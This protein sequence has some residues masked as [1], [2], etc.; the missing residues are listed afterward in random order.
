MLFA[1]QDTVHLSAASHVEITALIA[2]DAPEINR[3]DGSR[4]WSRK[5]LA[6]CSGLKEWNKL[7]SHCV[8]LSFAGASWHAQTELCDRCLVA[9]NIS[10]HFKA[11]SSTKLCCDCSQSGSLKI[12]ELWVLV[13]VWTCNQ[14][15]NHGHRLPGDQMAPG[16]TMGSRQTGGGSVM[17]F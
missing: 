4:G 16:C 12:I 15:N 1:L 3:D 17:I 2:G 13:M 10:W 5:R 9:V 8:F 14:W 7:L 11:S 6:S